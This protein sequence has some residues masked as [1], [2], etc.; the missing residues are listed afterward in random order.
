MR[1]AP[2]SL[3]LCKP[4]ASSQL[5]TSVFLFVNEEIILDQPS[6]PKS[7]HL[8]ITKNK[9]VVQAS[10]IWVMLE[11]LRIKGVESPAEPLKPPFLK[12]LCLPHHRISLSASVCLSF[13]GM[14]SRTTTEPS[15]VVSVPSA[16]PKGKREGLVESHKENDRAFVPG[17]LCGSYSPGW[18]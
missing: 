3:C 14:H 8:I 15:V 18:G 10:V 7:L 11:M 5:P 2:F 13:G 12:L 16:S 4:D 17:S 1:T 9:S 6:S